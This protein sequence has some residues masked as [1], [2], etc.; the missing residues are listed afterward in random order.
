MVLG[1]TTSTR[2]STLGNV[3]AGVWEFQVGGHQV[4]HKWLDE[5]RKAE[6]TLSEDD[7]QHYCRIVAVLKRTI[8]IM[9]EVDDVIDHHGGWPDASVT[10]D[11]GGKG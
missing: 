11:E 7:I 10:N 4:F 3:P 2:R 1:A 5:R 9:A 6:R 8:G